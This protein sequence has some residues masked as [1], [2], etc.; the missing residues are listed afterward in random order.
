LLAILFRI[1]VLIYLMPMHRN[2]ITSD[3]AG[4]T[5]PLSRNGSEE[6]LHGNLSEE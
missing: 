4:A 1:V 2:T 3:G 5:R 6:K